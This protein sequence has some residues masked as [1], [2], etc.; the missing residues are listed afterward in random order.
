MKSPISVF[1]RALLSTR[2]SLDCSFDWWFVDAPRRSG[3]GI[4][5][6]LGYYFCEGSFVGCF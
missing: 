2:F 3:A 5:F 1:T 4:C 6:I